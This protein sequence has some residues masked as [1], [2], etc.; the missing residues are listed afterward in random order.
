M[1]I[2]SISLP[3][4]QWPGLGG[5]QLIKYLG[6]IEDKSRNYLSF[7]EDKSRNYLSLIEDKSGNHLSFIEDKSSILIRQVLLH[8]F[9]TLIEERTMFAIL[10]GQGAHSAVV[11]F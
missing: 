1:H 5:D 7:I 6:F 9:F 2:I 10:R 8:P 3:G 11:Y 4:R